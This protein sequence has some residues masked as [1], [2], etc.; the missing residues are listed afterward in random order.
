MGMAAWTDLRMGA[1]D[2]PQ[3][4]PTSKD[5]AHEAPTQPPAPSWKVP[6]RPGLAQRKESPPAVWEQGWSHSKGPSNQ[7]AQPRAVAEMGAEARPQSTKLRPFQASRAPQAQEGAVATKEGRGRKTGGQ[8]ARR[9]GPKP[10]RPPKG[11]NWP[12]QEAPTWSQWGCGAVPESQVAEACPI[13]TNHTSITSPLN[14]A[15]LSVCPS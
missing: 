4:Q 14:P 7:W 6:T 2:W 8:G 5:G 3:P 11:E 10:W 1:L 15:L 9:K 12:R 13:F